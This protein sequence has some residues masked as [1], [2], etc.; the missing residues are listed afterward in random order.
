MMDDSTTVTTKIYD[1]RIL[2]PD[3][4]TPQRIDLTPAAE[5]L[6]IK[7]GDNS[8]DKFTTIKAKIAVIKFISG[9]Y[10][11]FTAF[12]DAAD[13]S[14]YVEITTGGSDTLFKGYLVLD[15]MSQNFYPDPNVVTLIASDHLGILKDIPLTDD[16][17]EVLRGKYKLSE[18]IAFCL[19]KTGLSLPIRVV[20]NLRHGSSTASYLSLFSVAGNYI[21]VTT[22]NFESY[23][24]AGQEITITGT[25]SNNGTFHVDYVVNSLTQE[26]HLIETIT[27][28]EQVTASYSDT[29]STSHFYD[30]IFVDAK[31]FESSIGEL[32]DCYTVLQKILGEDCFITQFDGKWWISRIDEY[33]DASTGGLYVASF[34]ANGLFSSLAAETNYNKRIG[35]AE[36]MRPVADWIISADRPLGTAVEKFDYTFPL[37]TP[38]NS[39]FARGDL[40]ATISDTEK[41]Y[42]VDYWNLQQGSIIAPTTPTVSAYT[43][44]IF[45][46]IGYETERYVVLTSRSSHA[47]A[48]STQEYLKSEA[49]PVHQLD[50]F[51]VSVDWRLSGNPTSSG[52]NY[53]LLRCFLN[54]DDGSWYILGNIDFNPDTYNQTDYNWWNTS[55]WTA[56]TGAGGQPITFGDLDDTQWRSL[57][58]DSPPVP[59]TGRVYLI[60]HQFNQITGATDDLN[61]HFTSLRF[62]YIPL[63]NGSYR[64][65]SGQHQKITRSPE[66]YLAK[67][68]NIVYLSDSPKKLINGAMFFISRFASIFSGS[69]IFTA[70]NSF[71]VSGD[72]RSLFWVTR[73]IK[74]TGTANNNITTRITSVSYS[75]GTN[76]TTVTVEGTTATETVSA[77]ISE[78]VFTI[79][80]RFYPHNVFPGGLGAGN[81]DHAHPY[82]EVQIRSV[83]NQY[84]NANRIFEGSVYK[85]YVS[86]DTPFKQT[87]L[88]HKYYLTD[89]SSPNIFNKYFLCNDMEQDW[90]TGVWRAIFIEVYDRGAGKVYD[91]T[92]EFKYLTE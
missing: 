3:G 74:I 44:R 37:E 86:T 5:P 73:H 32:E 17:S 88:I 84:R 61:I 19:K 62:E 87:D 55:V 65:Y 81:M 60:L 89:Y 21:S 72:Q 6:V 30:K 78:A 41:R 80:N 47:G 42:N 75:S 71:S 24:Y 39:D 51:T 2:I 43:T 77:T 34:D 36:T 49:I 18:V 29:S 11:D 1:T 35:L 33:D 16:G 48:D 92:R 25:A 69:T 15:G 22:T 20:N 58:W 8:R 83:F 45:N 31:T 38:E 56:N 91:D 40:S 12:A 64:K 54:G 52:G 57:S 76:R 70:S 23:F 4:D 27:T 63:I 46:D 66:S 90:K 9:N 67:R 68:E 28:G 13:N 59:V 7:T 82:G 50:K 85:N 53:Y 10:I 79:T 14:F 26:V